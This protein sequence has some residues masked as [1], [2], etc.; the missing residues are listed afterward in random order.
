M[1]ENKQSKITDE[2]TAYRKLIVAGFQLIKNS[3]GL[4][5]SKKAEALDKILSVVGF[6]P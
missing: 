3:D 2:L 6:V 5:Y 4:S 1:I